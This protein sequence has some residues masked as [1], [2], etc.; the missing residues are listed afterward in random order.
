MR[1]ELSPFR[2]RKKISGELV[3]ILFTCNS[4]GSCEWTDAKTG[5]TAIYMWEQVLCVLTGCLGRLLSWQS[6]AVLP[7]HSSPAGWYVFVQPLF[8]LTACTGNLHHQFPCTSLS[9]LTLLEDIRELRS[10]RGQEQCDS[11]STFQSGFTPENR[12][13]W[14]GRYLF[15]A[16]I[17]LVCIVPGRVLDFL[18]SGIYVGSSLGNSY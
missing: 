7:G 10:G 16:L 14:T 18:F 8:C 6:I 13:E 1:L 5:E 11:P 3:L 17:P 12:M 15:E 4:N 9:M 2:L